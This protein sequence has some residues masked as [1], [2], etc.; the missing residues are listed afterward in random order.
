MTSFIAMEKVITHIETRRQIA[1]SSMS[2][3]LQLL[4]I[5]EEEYC[6][7]KYQCGYQYLMIYTEYDRQA[8]A[9]IERT[10]KYWQWWKNHWTM[11]EEEFLADANNIFPRHRM[12][13]YKRLHSPA[14]L[15]QEITLHAKKLADSYAAMI[16][17]FLKSVS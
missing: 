16:V 17:D 13:H 4:N 6:W 10:R 5:T 7:H 12:K 11:R 14:I 2:Q 8:V 3:V 1:A 15:S 9:H